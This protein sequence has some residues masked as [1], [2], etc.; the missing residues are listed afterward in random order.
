[1]SELKPMVNEVISYKCNWCDE[2]Y[3]KES[4][5]D[6][7]SFKHARKNLANSL[8]R[9]DSVLETINCNCGFKWELTDEQKWCTKD[10]C[11]AMSHWQC[12]SKPAYK[13]TGINEEGQVMLWGKGGWSGYYGHYVSIKEL[14]KPHP[15]EDIFIYG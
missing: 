1:M 2:L 4:D 12:T 14:G 15:K 8:L 7:C 6:L 5:A 10:N 13:I 11:F 9:E 3:K